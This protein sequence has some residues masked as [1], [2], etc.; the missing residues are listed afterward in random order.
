MLFF[1][2]RKTFE[3]KT[4]VLIILILFVVLSACK[5]DVGKNVGDIY[6]SWEAKEFISLE[7]VGYP[8]IEGNKILLTFNR[9]GVFSLKLDVN[10]CGGNFTL[11]ENN[12]LEME[13]LICTEICSDSKF[14]EKLAQTLPKVTSFNID[15]KT[16][17]LNV[18]QW[19]YIELELSE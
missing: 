8:K 2:F 19:G 6:H 10:G 5:K 17:K 11:G 9:S 3:M 13:S 16:L 14:S 15:G 18:P 1:I 12:K 4:K 7:S